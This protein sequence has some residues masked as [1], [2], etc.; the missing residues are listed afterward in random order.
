MVSMDFNVTY[1]VMKV[2]EQSIKLLD[3]GYVTTVYFAAGFII[4]GYLN[5]LMGPFVEETHRSRS[6]AR[7]FAEVL[8]YIIFISLLIYWMRSL[9]EV[10]PFPLNMKAGYDRS[11]VRDLK[12]GWAFTFPLLLTQNYLK[13]KI[14][15]LHIRIFGKSITDDDDDVM[16]GI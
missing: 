11:R 9:M 8:L 3:I 16:L 12:N 14:E 15:Y 5:K 2:Q 1:I 7:I 4:G 13:D 10:V 6:T